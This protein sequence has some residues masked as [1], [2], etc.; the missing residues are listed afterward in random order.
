MCTTAEPDAVHDPLT[1]ALI[2]GV[3]YNSVHEDGRMRVVMD[4]EAFDAFL[5]LFE[6]R[7]RHLPVPESALDYLRQY[8]APVCAADLDFGGMSPCMRPV[9]VGRRCGAH[10]ALGQVHP[11]AS[12]A[13]DS[14]SPRA[15][16][17]WELLIEKPWL[18]NLRKD[19]MPERL[20]VS[21]S[22]ISRSL[23]ELRSMHLVVR[24]RTHW[25]TIPHPA[26]AFFG[27]AT[28]QQREL[29]QLDTAQRAAFEHLESAA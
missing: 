6:R 19:R 3:G 1:S 9:Q 12:Q 11:R 4:P 26:V 29:V 13:L 25:Q 15:R 8:R 18:R 16:R 23:T 20:D 22:T 17:F 27:P 2:D 10:P 7:K 14:L 28:L 5:E 24:S 21:A